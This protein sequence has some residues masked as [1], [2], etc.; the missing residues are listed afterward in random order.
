MRR[1][2]AVA[3]SL[4]A[5]WLLAVAISAAAPPR[6]PPPPAPG[7]RLHSGVEGLDIEL[8]AIDGDQAQIR[9]TLAPHAPGPPLH[10]HHGFD[11]VFQVAQGTLS[12]A[13]GDRVVA[14]AAGERL[15]IPRGQA[16]RPHNPSAEAVV[17]AGAEPTLPVDFLV[18]LAALYPCMDMAGAADAL[19]VLLQLA[20]LGVGVDTWLVGPP[21]PAQRLLRRA[22]SPIA[23]S[24]GF[25]HGAC[26]PVP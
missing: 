15:V 10:V 12:V 11:E 18:D 1:W 13:L 22:L 8:L 14:V 2:L 23:R 26:S 21:L 16:H 9:V 19:Q 6:R 25:G 4:L 7:T 20:A 24:A 5:L 17:L 3:C